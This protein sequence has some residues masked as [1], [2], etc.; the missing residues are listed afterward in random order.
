[1][2][3]IHLHAIQAAAVHGDDGALNINQVVLAQICCP[4]KPARITVPSNVESITGEPGKGPR[5]PT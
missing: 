4:L 3:R 5:W 2:A 1:M